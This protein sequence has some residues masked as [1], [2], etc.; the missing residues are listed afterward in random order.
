MSWSTPG[1][2]LCWSNLVKPGQPQVNYVGKQANLYQDAGYSLSGA[3]YVVEKYLGNTW[4]WDK[5]R[6][7]GWHGWMFS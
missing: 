2:T 6:L 3:A 1:Q 5:V 4:L 7:V